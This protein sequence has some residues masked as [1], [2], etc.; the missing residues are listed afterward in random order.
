MVAHSVA[1]SLPT[2]PATRILKYVNAGHNSPIVLRRDEDGCETLLLKPVGVPVGALE[3]SQYRSKSFQLEIGDVVVAY[4][5]GVTE[6][7]DSVGDPF[8]PER[9]ERTLCE[10]ACRD[11]RG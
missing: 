3:G 8:G 6:S 11:P 2:Q 4:T 7:E 1:Y 10:C 9:L 5:D